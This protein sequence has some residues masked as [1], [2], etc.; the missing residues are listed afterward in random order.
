MLLLI[1]NY[2]FSFVSPALPLNANKVN[3]KYYHDY[4]GDEILK[5][6]NNFTIISSIEYNLFDIYNLLF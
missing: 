6:K 4:D 2:R 5:G 3:G 1:F